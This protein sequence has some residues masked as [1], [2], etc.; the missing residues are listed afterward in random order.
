MWGLYMWKRIS[1]ELLSIGVGIVIQVLRI[2]P[3]FGFVL[4]VAGIAG[5]M[6]EAFSYIKNR[7]IRLELAQLMKKYDLV[8]GESEYHILEEDDK[9]IRELALHGIIEMKPT[10][11]VM[12]SGNVPQ[13]HWALTA[14][15]KKEALK[16]LNLFSNYR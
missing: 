4:I 10:P 5:F 13:I 11:V 6:L 16:S 2:S 9:T 14:K 3:W 15:G 8:K 1:S 7:K 12:P